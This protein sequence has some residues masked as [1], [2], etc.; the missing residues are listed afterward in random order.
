MNV[1]FCGDANVCCGIFL[2]AL[3][4]RKHTKQPLD[5]F[6]LTA[7]VKGHRPIPAEFAEK[8]ELLLSAEGGEGRVHLLDITEKFAS[9]IPTANM[10]TRFTPYCML[11]LFADLVE[12]LPDRMLY[13]DS[14]V[15]CRDCPD[16]LWETDLCG[17]ELAGVPDRYGKWFY[18]PLRHDYLNSGVLL[19]DLSAIRKSGLFEGCRRL[20]RDRRMLL[21]D[22]SALNRLAVKKRLPRRFNEQGR[23]RKNTVLKHFTTYFRFFPRFRAVTVKPWQTDEVHR[24]LKIYEFDPL[25]ETYERN[26]L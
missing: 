16:G 7:R 5:I 4:L 20:C 26:F 11:R 18:S 10:G 6:I 3:S 17:A 8:A 23:I 21:P 19:M 2:S 12:E 24:I 1:L 9:Y 22:Q 25:M 14:D 13:L 15:L